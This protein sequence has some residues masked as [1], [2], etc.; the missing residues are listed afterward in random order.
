[1]RKKRSGLQARGP[2]V[3]DSLR[4]K[5]APSEDRGREKMQRSSYNHYYSFSS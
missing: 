5:L 2:G 3:N 1:M 4:G